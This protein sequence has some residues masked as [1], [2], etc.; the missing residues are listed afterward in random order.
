VV[1]DPVGLLYP[2]RPDVIGSPLLAA[3][4]HATTTAYSGFASDFLLGYK[5][6]ACSLMKSIGNQNEGYFGAVSQPLLSLLPATSLFPASGSLLPF[7]LRE[8][9]LD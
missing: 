4:L 5:S 7:Y 6:A 1:L 9:V 3:S 2:C 8:L